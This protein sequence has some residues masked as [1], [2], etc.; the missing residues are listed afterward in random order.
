MCWDKTRLPVTKVSCQH[1]FLPDI[2]E[3]THSGDHVGGV[4]HHHII[5]QLY[6]C[7]LLIKTITST[8]GTGR[9]SR[10]WLLVRPQPHPRLGSSMEWS[11][12][13][14]MRA[15]HQ[16]WDP[17]K[18]GA[19]SPDH[20]HP[21]GSVF[22]LRSSSMPAWRQPGTGLGH[23]HPGQQHSHRHEAGRCK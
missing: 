14:G 1:W 23:S 19:H 13:Q 9:R 15:T 7:F 20:P 6:R 5:H 21:S 4:Y 22:C 18:A 12:P 17:P 16:V 11:D 8:W 2:Y 3:Y 10:Q